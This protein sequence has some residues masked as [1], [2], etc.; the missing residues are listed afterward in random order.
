M[1]G[2]IAAM[3]IA[4][5]VAGP[6]R[7][8]PSPP[9]QSADVPS[10]GD[11]ASAPP[12]D[13]ASGHRFDAPER[14]SVRR[15]IARAA[16]FVPRW[17]VW[18][19]FAPVRLGLWAYER[20]GAGFYLSALFSGPGHVFAHPTARFDSE[21]GTAF[22]AR[23]VYKDMF[24]AGEQLRIKASLGGQ[25]DRFYAARVGSGTRFG[26]V[27]F[28]LDFDY[29]EENKA[30]FA[31]LGNGELDSGCAAASL[32]GP[33]DITCATRFGQDTARTELTAELRAIDRLT[34][35]A[36]GALLLREFG[37]TG[38]AR[39]PD[40]LAVY[41]PSRL[42]GYNEGLHSLY[43]EVSATYDGRTDS[44][45]YISVALPHAGWSAAGFAGYQA[46][47]RDDPSKF[48][49]YGADLQGYL[50]LG[51]DDR[52]IALRVYGEAVT[53]DPETDIPFVDLPTLG[54]KRLLRGFG[55]GRFR[56][57]ALLLGSAE[58]HFPIMYYA[59]AF[60]FI[61]TGRVFPRLSDVTLHD[62]H[63]G[64]GGGLS[65]HTTELFLLRFQTGYSAEENEFHA[66]L[67]FEPTFKAQPRAQ[68]Y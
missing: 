29:K 49:R 41:D 64:V 26:P 16:L 19:A 42:A 39:D 35:A 38:S 30:R 51:A 24:G 43:G 45:Q 36:S 23:G 25:F 48:F 34:L 22:G 5:L 13:E 47:L 61:D 37:P 67:V 58:Y 55:T 12:A 40:L 20:S 17:T 44:T 28:V 63:T 11:V 68:R 33:R 32:A 54:G 3:F 60:L 66:S 15:R 59:S 56:D 21:F 1:R 9:A 10:S 65:L 57:K 7:A 50:A 46:G 4:A 31:G 14:P 52:L 2:A 27:R 18:A 8:Q 53:G 6:A 62:L